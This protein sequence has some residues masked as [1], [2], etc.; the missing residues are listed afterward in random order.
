MEDIYHLIIEYRNL[1]P[2]VFWGL[3]SLLSLS[4]L[5]IVAKLFFKKRNI[6][7][8]KP[9]RRV[10]EPQKPKSSKIKHSTSSSFKSSKIKTKEK[11]TPKESQ[12]ISEKSQKVSEPK[13]NYKSTEQLKTTSDEIKRVKKSYTEKEELPEV[14]KEPKKEI[15]QNLFVNYSSSK[16]NTTSSYPVFMSPNKGCIVRSHRIG[17]TKRRGYKEKSFQLSIEKYFSPEF[18]VSGNIRL[19]TG[20]ETR[21]F[22]PDIAILDLESDKNIRIDIEIDEPYAGITRQA[23]HCDDEDFLRDCYFVDRGWIVIRF[24]EYQVHTQL[25]KCLKYIANVITSINP[26]YSIPSDLKNI[27]E[28]APEPF[29]DLVQAQKWEKEKYREKYLNH[30]FQEIIEKPE[31]IVRDLDD[32]EIAEEKL[33]TPSVIGEVDGRNITSFNKVNSHPR[34]KR[35]EFYPEPHIYTIDGISAPSASTIVSKF[36]PEFDMKYWAARKAPDLGMSPEE[37][38]KMWEEKGKKARDKGTFLHEQIEKYYLGENYTETEAF[39]L[40]KQFVDDH[41]NLSPYRSE[42]RVFD[43]KHHIAGTIDLI[44]KNGSGYEIYD[45]KRSKKVVN[46][47]DGSPITANSWQCGIGKLSHMDD[48][49][50]NRYCLQQSLYRFI[51]EKNYGIKLSKMFLVI[52]YPQY[53]KYYKLEAPYFKEETEYI[54]NIL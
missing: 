28:I 17:S 19:N 49:S 25:L 35:I 36:F 15:K 3:V 32:Q 53:D 41:P 29:W 31:T 47:F 14:K 51:L 43:D 21:P 7:E 34:D 50:Y 39:S 33:V 4:F 38:E 46:T 8:I 13:V 30:T 12:S 5:F 54:L 42:W 24:S 22:E 44:A 1:Y 6:Q 26:E 23:T 16:K 27:Q 2:F 11:I 20:K 45:W 18:K 52:F 40:F 9:N 10:R 48:T 37:V